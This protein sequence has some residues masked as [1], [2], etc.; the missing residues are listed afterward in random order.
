MV[1]RFRTCDH[2]GLN[3]GR[4]QETPKESWRTR[5][6]KRCEYCNADN[7]QKNLNYEKLTTC[8][9]FCSVFRST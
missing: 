8:K 1:N 7:N 5:Q 3:K 9:R 2:C 4:K 6:P